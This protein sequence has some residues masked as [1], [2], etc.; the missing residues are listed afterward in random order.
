MTHFLYFKPM[1]ELLHY[2]WKHRLFELKPLATTDG[3]PVEVIDPGLPNRNAGPDFFNAKIRINGTL[4]VGNVELHMKADEWFAHHHDRDAHYD[5]V[6]LHV[7]IQADA[8][9]VTST[10][11]R[12]SQMV[13]SIPEKVRSHYA[14]L[15]AADAYPP[16]Y[17]IIPQLSPL[18]VHSWMSALQV[19]RLQQK[20]EAIRHR[21][22]LCG[23][24]WEAAFF[25]TL[26]RNYGFGVNG[27]AFEQWALSLPL[28][29]AAHHRDD[30]FQIEALFLGTAGLLDTQAPGNSDDAYRTKLSTEYAYLAHK[31]GLH[32]I[33][34]KVWRFLRLRPQNFPYIRISQLVSLYC[35]RRALLGNLVECSS[36]KQAAQLMATQATPYWQDHYTFGCKASHSNKRLSA[37]SVNLI[38][39]NT[40]V[41]ML[42]AYGRHRG[43]EQLCSRALEFLDSLKA[44]SNHIVRQWAQ[45]GL[46]VKTA[47]DS[48]ALIQLKKQ[49]CDR[50]DCLRCR[51]GYEYLK[52]R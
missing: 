46:S 20:T 22:D 25:V 45:C 11:R 17:R 41:P 35:S 7:C 21:A 12:P 15:L 13:L 49:Y 29:A 38:L 51:I 30:I 24:D 19:E 36:L 39:I 52:N 32:A 3:Q 48:Q 1:E 37:A 43:N 4:W 44:E 18:M 50:K 31:F 14:E 28:Q 40:F 9:A 5:N 26:A 34:G 42:Y 8:E 33:D 16:C 27:D 6:I 23:G 2:V 47:G 10:G